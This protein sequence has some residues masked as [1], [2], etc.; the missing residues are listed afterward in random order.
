MPVLLSSDYKFAQGLVFS[1]YKFA[2]GFCS[3]ASDEESIL[4]AWPYFYFL[5]ILGGPA[6]LLNTGLTPY[7]LPLLY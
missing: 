4:A 6:E 5:L 7:M 1:C 2:Q 3:S